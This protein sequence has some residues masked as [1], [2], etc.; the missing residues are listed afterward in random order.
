VGLGAGHAARASRDWAVCRGR[1]ERTASA[2]QDQELSLTPT[3]LQ[4]YVP[5][6]LR[7][8]RVTNQ[9]AISCKR[10]WLLWNMP[11]ML[12]TLATFQFVMGW[13]KANALRNILC[14]IVTLE[15]FQLFRGWLK[16]LASKN[17]SLMSVTLETSQ[18]PMGWLNAGASASI[19]F[20]VVTLETS[21]RPMG[22]LNSL[23]ASDPQCHAPFRCWLIGV[24]K[25][26][27]DMLVT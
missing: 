10:V 21:H 26:L 17:I 14:I 23:L 3:T 11:F 8:R 20:I 7:G 15:T 1:T 24:K 19:L 22:W 16:V 12:V 4:P 13:S 27:L 6:A 2:T 25:E 5:Y 18:S 9:D